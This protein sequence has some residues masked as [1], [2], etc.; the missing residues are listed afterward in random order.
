M[1]RVVTV[2]RLPETKDAR[3]SI[4]C[5]VYRESPPSTGPFGQSSKACGKRRSVRITCTHDSQQARQ[6]KCQLVFVTGEAGIGKTALVEAFAA[7]AAMDQNIWTVRVECIEQYGRAKP[8][9]QSWRR[10]DVCVVRRQGGASSPYCSVWRQAGCTKCPGCWMLR[11]VTC[12]TTELPST[13]QKG[14]L[15]EIAEIIEALTAETPLLLV[16]EDLHWSDYATLDLIS[17]LVRRQEAS[18]IARHWHVS[19]RG[20]HYQ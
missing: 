2:D 8:I 11:I 18:S 20:D 17:F 16:L 9:C 4:A 19:T 15:L 7:Q 3:S 6:G 14:M 1:R 5:G 12:Y 13:T 10:W